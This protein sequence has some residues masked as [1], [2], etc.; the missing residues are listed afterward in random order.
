MSTKIFVNLAVKDLEKSKAFFG[1]L[2]YTF[3]PQFSD[4]TATCMII[5]DDIYS[6]LLTE[7]KFKQFATKPLVDAHK[8]TEV[9]IALSQESREAV[10]KLVDTAL[11]S[12]GTE[13]RPADDHGFMYQ[14]S[15]ADLDGH[16]WEIFWMDPKFA[17]GEAPA[18]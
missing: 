14:R 18:A 15:Y 2:G 8:A 4:D 6:M 16:V 3:N 11:A 10:D 13:P 5:S 7:P 17:A 9:L 12:G 1:K